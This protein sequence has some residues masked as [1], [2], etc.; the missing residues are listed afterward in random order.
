M[1]I[2]LRLKIKILFSGWNLKVKFF[3]WRHSLLKIFEDLE[4]FEENF[5]LKLPSTDYLGSRL[6]FWVR[7]K[8]LRSKSST[9]CKLWSCGFKAIY[10]WL[11]LNK[12]QIILFMQEN[13]PITT[14]QE[15]EVGQWERL[16]AELSFLKHFFQS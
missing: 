6:S 14:E 12:R 16:F 3:S 9:R 2:R 4:E 13:N 11:T 8:Q 10:L 7:S 1:K 15:T 5:W